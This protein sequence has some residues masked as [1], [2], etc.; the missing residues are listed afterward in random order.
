MGFSRGNEGQFCIILPPLL[1]LLKAKL[2]GP[3]VTDPEGDD[4]PTV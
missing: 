3:K 2:P 4:K 1:L